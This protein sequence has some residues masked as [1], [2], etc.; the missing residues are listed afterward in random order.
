MSR[1]AATVSLA[2]NRDAIRRHL[3]HIAD[4]FGEGRFDAPMLVHA[5]AVPGTDVLTRLKA[6]VRYT[7]VETPAGG[8]TEKII[9]GGTEERRTNGEESTVFIRA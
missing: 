5:P 8:R 1:F 3:P 4:L 6:A 9:T 2:V 7:Y